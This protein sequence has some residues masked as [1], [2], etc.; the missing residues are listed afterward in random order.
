[1]DDDACSDAGSSQ[2]E[3]DTAP[4][5]AVARPARAALQVGST[6]GRRSS[7]RPEGCV[8]L[9]NLGNTCFMNSILQCLNCV[10]EF[11][12]QMRKVTWHTN[13]TS[14]GTGCDPGDATS[15]SSSTPGS[16]VAKGVSSSSSSSSSAPSSPLW[17]MGRAQ[18]QQQ[19]LALQRGV[20]PAYVALLRQMWEAGGAPATSAVPCVS[21]ARLLREVA[22]KDDR[23]G[24]GVQQDSQEFLT[25]LLEMLQ[26]RRD[27]CTAKQPTKKAAVVHAAGEAATQL[28]GWGGEGEGLYS[29]CMQGG[30][31]G[32]R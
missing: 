10:P 20:G 9:A 16:P 7:T 3:D 11:V 8:G 15:G 2:S 32:A 5:V 29:G 28:W 24:E 19:P 22:V 31:T 30:G 21:P 27:R 17:R 6:L 13:G 4:A 23:W 25:S 1:V 26:V 12:A 14:N 18:S